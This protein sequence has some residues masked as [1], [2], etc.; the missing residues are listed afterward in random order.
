MGEHEMQ[1]T[2][3]KSLYHRYLHYFKIF[4]PQKSLFS[5]FHIDLTDGRTNLPTVG[6][7][8]WPK[9]VTERRAQPLIELPNLALQLRNSIIHIPLIK[10]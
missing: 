7:T 10:S 5:L 2:R 1:K 4:K 6:R 3:C 8:D 9:N